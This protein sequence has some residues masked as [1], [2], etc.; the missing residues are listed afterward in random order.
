MNILKTAIF[1]LTVPGAVVVYVPWLL[2]P[3]DAKVWPPSSGPLACV[4]LMPMLFG[5]LIL[6]WCATDF[7][8]VGKGTPAPIDPPKELVVRG[9]YRY[10]RNP[11]YVG[12]VSAL[13]G[14]A[15]LFQSWT[16]FVYAAVCAVIMHTFVVLYE[17]PT[18]RKKFGPAYEAYLVHVPRWLGKVKS[19]SSEV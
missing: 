5:A 16:L 6:L 3:P 2:L 13:L 18:L 9:L 7:V 1:T 12:A 17:E 4:A 14:E 15:L 8:R 10:S 19:R 11:M